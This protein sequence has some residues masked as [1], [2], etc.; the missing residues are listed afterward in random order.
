MEML[1]LHHGRHKNGKLQIFFFL[2]ILCKLY[3]FGFVGV[4]LGGQV[5]A[6]PIRFQRKAQGPLEERST[7]RMEEVGF[8]PNHNKPV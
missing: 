4:G 3:G 5:L 7:I 8:G 6:Y 1:N 2:Y